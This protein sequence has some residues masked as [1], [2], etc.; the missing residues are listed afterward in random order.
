M[1]HVIIWEF[2]VRSH[3]VHEF[4]A[5]YGSDGT[6]AALFRRAPEYLGT[7]LLRDRDDPLRFLTID[8]WT[9]A[10][11]FT[12]FR[13]QHAQQYAELDAKCADWTESERSLGTFG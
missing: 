6:W 5:A 1:A 12:R 10:D 3:H 9:S 13:E 4:L 8:R 11:A 7:E 2:R